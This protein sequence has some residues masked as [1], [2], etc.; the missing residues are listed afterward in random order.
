M[1]KVKAVKVTREVKIV[2][3]KFFLIKKDTHVYNNCYELRSRAIKQSFEEKNEEFSL[4]ERNRHLLNL[5]F[6]DFKK[7]ELFQFSF[8]R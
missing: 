1:Q 4:C 5:Y 2:K 6:V 8:S 7:L 3:Q